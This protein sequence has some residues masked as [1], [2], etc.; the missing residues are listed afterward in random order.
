MILGGAAGERGGVCV[1]VGGGD[2]WW[3]GGGGV[4]VVGGGET[5]VDASKIFHVRAK[6]R[7]P[8]FQR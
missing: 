8:I 1:C 7:C 4:C 6:C 3:S 2:F 5:E